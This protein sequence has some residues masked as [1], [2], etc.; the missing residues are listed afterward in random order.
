MT[1][2]DRIKKDLS[3]LYNG[4]NTPGVIQ[5]AVKLDGVIADKL[6]TKGMPGHFTGNRNA[7]NI[8]V[9]L[10]PGK[11]AVGADNALQEEITKLSID[12]SSEYRFIQS[13]KDAKTNFGKINPNK[14]DPFDIKQ[15]EFFKAWKYSDSGINIP[16]AFPNDKGKH[17]A[18]TEEVLMN[19]LQLELIPY[20]SSGFKLR[21]KAPFYEYIETLFDEIF[22]KKRTYVIF[23]SAIF[24]TLFNNR[25]GMASIGA[26][27]TFTEK[28]YPQQ[29]LKKKDGT[30]AKTNFSCTR[31]RIM[32]KGKEYK[33][34]IAPTFFV[35]YG[36]D[37]IC[38]YGDFCYKNY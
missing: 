35:Q 32:Y 7:K 6:S 20:C 12:T 26:C 14:K 24:E 16:E 33:A 21:K 3:E 28:R 31:I 22:S 15:A 36:G 11:D 8:L 4:G 19:K 30:P 10:N 1:L 23:A 9:T 29:P 37:L 34:M 17:E 13:Y 2:D 5:N 25:K 18:A 38:Q 27:L